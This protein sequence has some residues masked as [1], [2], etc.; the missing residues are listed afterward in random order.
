[1]KF[2]TKLT[3]LLAFLFPYG[4][5]YADSHDEATM[6]VI[7]HSDSERYENEIELPEMHDNESHSEDKDDDHSDSLDDSNDEK[8]DAK[9]DEKEDSNEGTED[10]TD[11]TTSTPPA[12]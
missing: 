12:A 10:S 4:I 3:L 1:M 9:E 11:D 6:D 8:E 7:E 5:T 2:L